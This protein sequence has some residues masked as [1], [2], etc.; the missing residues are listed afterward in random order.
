MKISVSREFL[1]SFYSATK[2][3]SGAKTTNSFTQM[4]RLA[5]KGG[6]LT[7]TVTDIDRYVRSSIETVSCDKD[8]AMVMPASVIGE[9]ASLAQGD[10]LTISESGARAAVSCGSDKWNVNTADPDDYPAWP[11]KEE[12]RKASFK[13]NSIDLKGG[14]EKTSDMISQEKGRYALNGVFIE[15]LGDRVEFCGT[16]G[17][18]LAWVR[19]PASGDNVT[20]MSE[21]PQIII[22]SGGCTLIKKVLPDGEIGI[23]IYDECLSIH[24]DRTEII[25]RLVEG[26][27]PDYRSVLPNNLDKTV[28]VEVGALSGALSRARLLTSVESQAVKLHFTNG[29]AV[30]SAR[31]PASGD[32]TISCPVSYDGPEV[33]VGVDPSYLQTALSAI[34]GGNVTVELKD[35]DTGIMLSGVDKSLEYFLVMPIDI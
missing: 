2:M 21:V 33:E 27:F 17:R 10:I 12:R 14:I 31:S 7:A 24:A 5:V 23:D 13:M 22:P 9:I 30:L 32:A 29:A 20:T 35:K 34:E 8:G 18:R 6:V 19:R 4:M 25:V 26:Q 16:D 1:A 3:I 15:P 11:V 28:K